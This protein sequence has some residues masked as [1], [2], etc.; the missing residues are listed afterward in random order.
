MHVCREEPDKDEWWLQP[1]TCET[2]KCEFMYS[3]YPNL[4]EYPSFC[5]NCGIK[6]EALRQE[7]LL[8]IGDYNKRR[9]EK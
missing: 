7:N 6:F 1:Y 5:P 9:Y 8:I 2:C 3:D 4:L